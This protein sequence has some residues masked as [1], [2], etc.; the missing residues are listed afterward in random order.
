MIEKFLTFVKLINLR[1]Y[2]IRLLRGSLHTRVQG[3][4]GHDDLQ[5]APFGSVQVALTGA[6][7]GDVVVE[8][9]LD[10][11]GSPYL[12]QCVLRCSPLWITMG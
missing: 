8:M 12:S 9:S 7:C 1:K 3:L 5:D 6:Q 11:P 10:F 2:D 4:W